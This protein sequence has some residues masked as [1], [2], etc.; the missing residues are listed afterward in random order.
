MWKSISNRTGLLLAAL[1][2]LTAA[3]ALAQDKPSAGA[4]RAK[5]LETRHE[6]GTVNEGAVVVHE[7]GLMN[8]GTGQLR[9][10]ELVPA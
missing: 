8:E 5:F 3:S 4:P 7:F 10:T 9:I 6:V 1:S 2:L